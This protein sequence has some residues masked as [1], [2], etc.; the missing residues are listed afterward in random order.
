MNA[1]KRIIS[2]DVFRGITVAFMILVNDPGIEKH[3]YGPMLHAAWNGFTPTDLIFPSFIFIAGLSV[4]LSFSRQLSTGV[5]KRNLLLKMLK[6]VALLYLL[7]V[8]LSVMQT[9]SFDNLRIMGVLQ[10]IAIVTCCCALLFLYT[11]K[12]FQ[13]GL[14]ISILVIYFLLF[15]LVPVPGYGMVI[16]EPGKNLAAWFDGLIIPARFYRLGWEPEGILSS[17]TAVVTGMAGMFTGFL[18]RSEKTNEQKIIWLFF[19]GFASFVI[20]YCLDWFF[21]INKNIWTSSFVL[22]CAGLDCMLLGFLYFLVDVLGYKKWA[23]PAIVFGSN[24]IVGY[25]ASEFFYDFI[26]YRF[27]GAGSMSLNEKI[28]AVME[29]TGWSLEFISAFWAVLFVVLCY[30]PVYILYKRKIFIRL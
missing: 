3:V 9:F 12:K 20:G 8:L 13:I 14:A 11:G 4:E 18:L 15:K 26:Y 19:A 22:L 7:G 5:P 30:L 27:G 17:F 28:I 2:L 24:A 1:T 16:V 10:R 29:K 21:P 6:R 23:F 25:F